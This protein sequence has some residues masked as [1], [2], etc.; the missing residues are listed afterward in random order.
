MKE[1]LEHLIESNNKLN[2]MNENWDRTMAVELANYALQHQESLIDGQVSH[3][4]VEN[5]LHEK[6]NN[7]SNN[8]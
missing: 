7:E 5:F 4:T 1:F 3:A 2:T 6:T 8:E